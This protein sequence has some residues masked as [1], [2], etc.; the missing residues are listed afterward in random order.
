MENYLESHWSYKTKLNDLGWQLN[1]EFLRKDREYYLG[2]E[3]MFD[4]VEDPWI[5]EHQM[6][7]IHNAIKEITNLFGLPNVG[8][9][10]DAGGDLNKIVERQ[11]DAKEKLVT[12]S[13]QVN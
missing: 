3:T 4:L 13:F 8:D 11:F 1:V 10:I 5:K 7:E 12:I 9:Y 2:K 6:L